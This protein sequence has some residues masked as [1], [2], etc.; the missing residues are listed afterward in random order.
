MT[1]LCRSFWNAMKRMAMFIR[2]YSFTTMEKFHIL[3]SLPR[4]ERISRL[5]RRNQSPYKLEPSLKN[6]TLAESAVNSHQERR[7]VIKY[8]MGYNRS[9]FRRP[10]LY[11]RD[12][13]N[14]ACSFSNSCVKDFPANGEESLIYWVEEVDIDERYTHDGQLLPIDWDEQLKQL[15]EEW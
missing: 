15:T 14:D 1:Q 13:A 8:S 12:E 5:L 7:F 10:Y 6:L 9:V 4:N 2:V 3:S 11:T